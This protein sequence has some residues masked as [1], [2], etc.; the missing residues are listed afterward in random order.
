MAVIKAEE[1]ETTRMTFT[2]GNARKVRGK[3]LFALVDVEV[4]IA[5]ITFGILGVQIHKTL[6]GGTGVKMPTYK[7]T[8]GLWRQA[9]S[10]PPEVKNPLGEAVLAFLVDMDVARP[11]FEAP[12]G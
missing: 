6:T 8:D 11:R 7:D 1:S 3:T 5:G 2:I 9:V 12:G 10:M 4:E